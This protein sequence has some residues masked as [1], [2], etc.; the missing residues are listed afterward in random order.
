MASR[1]NNRDMSLD[2]ST[3]IEELYADNLSDGENSELEC[4]SDDNFSVVSDSDS[5]KSEWKPGSSGNGRPAREEANVS[6][7]LNVV[8][9]SDS[10]SE[11]SQQNV[12]TVPHVVQDVWSEADF[13]PNTPK[14]TAS[15]GVQIH[16]PDFS[17]HS[18]FELFVGDDFLKMLVEESNLYR[19]QMSYK[20][21]T[22]PKALKWSDV[23]TSDMKKCIGLII[24]MGQIRKDSIKEYWSTDPY[25]ETPVFGKT[26]SR[27]RFEDIWTVLHFNNNENKT[28]DSGRLFKVQ[29]V[30]DYLL[31]KFKS[32]YTPH[33][34][35]SL[36]EAMMPWRG[37]LRFRT[38][39]PGKIVKYG[40]LIREV[41]EAKTGYI[42]NLVIYS[43]EGKSLED[44]ILSVLQPVLDKGYHL[45]QDN[46]YNS[47]KIVEKLE[48]RKTVVCGTIR[49]NRGVPNSLKVKESGLKKGEMLFQ[50]KG[51]IL[52]QLWKDKRIVRMITTI[53]DSK[54]VR[55]TKKTKK[56]EDV[57]KPNAVLDYNKY[58]AGVDR[59]DQY[60]SYYSILR[61]TV[62]WSKKLFFYL[63][64]CAL[65]NSF[66]VYKSLQSD[67][68]VKY[69]VYLRKIAKHLI[70]CDKPTPLGVHNCPDNSEN[71]QP[72]KPSTKRAPTHDPPQ[73]LSGNFGKHILQEIVSSGTKKYPTRE[74][75]VC[76]LHNK[77]KETR[78][79][80]KECNIPLHKGTCFSS[81]HS[82]QHY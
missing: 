51:N 80:C 58:M 53:H 43:G 32:V 11:N 12:D 45:Y 3:I 82:K 63:L 22:S 59:A 39:N 15:P 47:V 16:P 52:V 44:T 20:N 73:R 66:V 25:L 37:R 40:L 65:F 4:D 81:Y 49:L 7:G 64:N 19:V 9:D 76:K 28:D 10:D 48:T 74:C 78:Y 24:L 18:C 23:T 71:A 61:K 30:L 42:T 36:D 55:T 33:R 6:V 26:L 60:L 34:E 8:Y 79:V 31:K 68:K 29:P 35:I 70:E 57:I 5:E 72:D 21:I 54:M 75:K 46:Y 50:R 41:C 17:A 77:R 2:S 56:G 14:F 27:S 1:Q 38:Y 69:K 13:Q 67:N 62:K